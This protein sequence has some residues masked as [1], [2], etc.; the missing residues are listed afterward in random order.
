MKAIAGV[1]IALT[2]VAADK[3]EFFGESDLP[4]SGPKIGKKLPYILPVEMV[5]NPR[6]S[7]L[8]TSL[9]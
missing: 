4:T 3:P 9:E 2:C 5:N 8:S 7:G 1:M 6:M